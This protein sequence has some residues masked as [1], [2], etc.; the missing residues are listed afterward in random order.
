M[1]RIGEMAEDG[2]A[3]VSVSYRAS[4]DLFFWFREASAGGHAETK[5]WEYE[6]EF[7][8]F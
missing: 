3:G 7:A 1:A 4:R 2:M 5:P 6:S 8:G